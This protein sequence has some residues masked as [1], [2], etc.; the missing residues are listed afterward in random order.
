[1]NKIT[2]VK[3]SGIEVVTNDLPA[4]IEAAEKAGWKRK[5]EQK[6]E[7]SKKDK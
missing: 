3:P 2:W 5:E 6:K 7:E 4:N 1:M